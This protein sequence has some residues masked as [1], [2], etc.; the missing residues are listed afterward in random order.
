[1]SVETWNKHDHAYERESFR[2]CRR[3]AGVARTRSH[4]VG[5]HGYM[6]SSARARGICARVRCVAPETHEVILDGSAGRSAGGYLILYP[7]ACCPAAAGHTTTARHGPYGWSG[8]SEGRM[9]RCSRARLCAWRTALHAHAHVA[10]PTLRWARM[11][12][13]SGARLLLHSCVP[14]AHP[15]WGAQPERM[16]GRL[17]PSPDRARP[18]FWGA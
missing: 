6:R 16:R 15:C 18:P 3:C 1:M 5:A 11:C 12:A 9:P 17:S 8:V 2:L 14:Q 10:V 7:C 4:G 13:P